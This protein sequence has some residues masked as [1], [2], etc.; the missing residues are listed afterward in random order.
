MS[1][2]EPKSQ[3]RA[4]TF[5]EAKTVMDNDTY[6][7][8]DLNLYDNRGRIVFTLSVTILHI[9]H[10]TKGHSHLHDSEVYEFIEG[11]GFMILG[12]EAINVKAGDYIFVDANTFHKVV[13]TSNASDLV[14]R[15][16]FAGQIR[17]PHL[18]VTRQ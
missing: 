12:T 13:N 18:A 15:C 3:L 8:D 10:Q 11:T 1:K 16:Y 17:R 6:R 14:F 2:A 9:G 5:D 7:I 4:F